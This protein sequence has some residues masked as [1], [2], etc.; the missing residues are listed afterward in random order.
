VAE[1]I[2][3]SFPLSAFA[4][5]ALSDDMEDCATAIPLIRLRTKIAMKSLFMNFDAIVIS[6]PFLVS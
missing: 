4:V 1:L 2:S 6:S 3:T 5:V